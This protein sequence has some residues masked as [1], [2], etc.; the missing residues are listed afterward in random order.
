MNE[1]LV[2]TPPYLDERRER[3]VDLHSFLNILNVISVSLEV[4]SL[5][6]PKGFRGGIDGKRKIIADLVQG[7]REGNPVADLPEY[8]RELCS[9]ILVDVVHLA[10]ELEDGSA[11]DDVGEIL[12]NLR[13]VFSILE[14]RLDELDTCRE[15]ADPWIEIDTKAFGDLFRD[16]FLAI[17]KNARNRYRI[18]FNLA[19]KKEEDY[20]I[21][22]N[23]ETT[24]SEQRLWI[25]LRLIDVLRDLAANG[26][27]YSK[28]GG[29][30][31]LAVFQDE[32]E[33]RAVVEDAGCGIPEQELN[34]V[35]EFGYRA[36]NVAGQPTMGGG[37]GLTKAAFLVLR[38]GGR[39]KIASKEGKGTKIELKIPY[40]QDARFGKYQGDQNGNG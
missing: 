2:T 3:I 15:N 4:V 21:D 5:I 35:V 28:P 13:S 23:V 40:R 26:R 1:F 12:E 27:K 16:V 29:K 30:V 39:M 18:V 9:F 32:N 24:R 36:S 11:R 34:R 14:T 22:L 17:A 8:L 37:F 31:A 6:A 25:P 19:L 33:I 7:L 20:Y 10:D 38:W